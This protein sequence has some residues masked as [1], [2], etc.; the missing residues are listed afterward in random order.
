MKNQIHF[1]PYCLNIRTALFFLSLVSLIHSNSWCKW[2]PQTP[3]CNNNG[4]NNGGGSGSGSGG[5]GGSGGGSGTPTYPDLGCASQTLEN[6]L[7]TNGDF[8]TPL[9]SGNYKFNNP[10]NMNGWTSP[11]TEIGKG[12][13]YNS[14]WPTG[15][16]V[17]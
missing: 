10:G 8:E 12:Q 14:R 7:S 15:T 9:I 17:I 4:N 2:F 6:D 5:S 16:Q 13:F 3:A 1:S 11:Q